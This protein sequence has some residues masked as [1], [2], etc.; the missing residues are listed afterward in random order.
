MV[1]LSVYSI[2]N[3][4]FMKNF[5]HKQADFRNYLAIKKTL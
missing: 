1:S 4:F 3:Y 2:L 5:N